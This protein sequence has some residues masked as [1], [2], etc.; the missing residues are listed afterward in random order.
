MTKSEA[1]RALAGMRK[2]RELHCIGCG[3]SFHAVDTR[4]KYCSNRCRQKMKYQRK[5]AE[6]FDKECV[7]CGT[8]MFLNDK[9]VKYCSTRCRSVAA[10]LRK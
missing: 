9:R 6:Y 8:V 4:A 2:V 1:A 10:L 3:E 5:I 7:T